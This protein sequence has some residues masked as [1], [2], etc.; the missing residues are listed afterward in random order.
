LNERELQAAI[1]MPKPT[2]ANRLKKKQIQTNK[3]TIS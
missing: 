3:T 2:I 1:E